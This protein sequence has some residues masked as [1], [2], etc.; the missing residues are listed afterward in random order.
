MK[1]LK[2]QCT[3]TLTYEKALKSFFNYCKRKGV[4]HQGLVT[5][6]DGKARRSI[7]FYKGNNKHY[8]LLDTLLGNYKPFIGPVAHLESLKV[9]INHL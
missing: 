7:K 2:E 4:E 1:K 6:E 8:F 3:C 9:Y 5:I